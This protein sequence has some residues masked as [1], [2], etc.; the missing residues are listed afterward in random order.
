MNETEEAKKLAKIANEIENVLI[1]N[2]AQLDDM[3]AVFGGLTAMNCS[4]G[5]KIMFYG[6][7]REIERAA[8]NF[9]GINEKLKAEYE[10]ANDE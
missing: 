8:E 5:G 4:R 6:A 2:G 9:I 10:K 3:L 7:L 1:E